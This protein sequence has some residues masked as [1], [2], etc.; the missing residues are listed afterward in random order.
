MRA[1]GL[2]RPFVLT[3]AGALA[4]CTSHDHPQVS[5]MNWPAVDAEFLAASSATLGFKLGTPRFV[6]FAPD[7]TLLF[8]RTPARSRTAELFQ[9]DPT[10]AVSTVAT[11]EQLL[12]GADEHLSDADKARRERTR[13]VTQGIVDVELSRDGARLLV[14]LGERMFLV[15]RASGAAR[16][17]DLSG[18]A[19]A[20]G[21][22][23]YP[24]DPHFSPDGSRIAY[25]VDGDLFVVDT[26]GG[27][28]R[29]LTTRE[30][31]TIEHGVAEFVAQEELFRT[32][33]YWWSPDG[34]H[35]VYQRTDNGP[36]D[37]L[38]VAD[39]VHPEQAPV[40]FRYPRAG[41]P[42][43]EI[44]LGIVP[45]AGGATTWV[46]WDHA[47]YPYLA[48]VAWPDR[49]PL[50]LTVL[51]RDQNE[52]VVLAVHP[53]TG[54]TTP[55]LTE[56]DDAW[57]EAVK[58]VPR[59]LDDGSGFL[60]MS[61]RS[62]E[63]QL[64]LR[65]RGGE[66][67]RALTPPGFGLRRMAGVDLARGVAWVVASADP[68]RA[69]VWLVPLDGKNP[70]RQVSTA[71]G[72]WSVETAEHGDLALA[73]GALADG[74]TSIVVWG[75]DGSTRSTVPSAAEKPPYQAHPTFETVELAGRRYFTATTRPRAFDAT[76]RYPVLVHVYGGPGARMVMASP[77]DFAMDQWY[78]DAGFIVVRIDGRGTPNQGR[79][80]SRAV[81][82]DLVT[83]PL[84][85]Q[86]DALAALGARHGELDLG[87]V[88]IYGWS[89]GGYLAAMAV[90]LRP[91]IF[92]CAVAGAPVTDWKL[93]DTA[94]T[95]RYMKQP[96]ENPDGY[97]ATSALTHAAKLAR[98]LLVIHGLTDDNV[99]VAHSLAL[100][101]A[102]FAAGKRADFVP[103]SST[104][105][106]PDPK[107]LLARET[108]QIDFFREH[109]GR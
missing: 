52:L 46:T 81:L 12:S 78:A 16:A 17:I 36:V 43:A 79:A 53:T 84:A 48:Q 102:L 75:S 26:S 65:D 56:H 87:R 21:A 76:H 30:R 41:R 107:I 42:N 97:A 10:G 4:A 39:A 2:A 13:T 58:G 99:H 28:P 32:R 108:L 45:S 77:H 109:L 40:P 33:G 55:L 38:Y 91:E 11:A 67:V 25:V 19:F 6:A 92:R 73:T 22:G 69:D 85:D 106:V 60:W 62:G 54:A 80:W 29:R 34:G 72:V 66:H 15:E 61:E 70:P 8:L 14:P 89:F 35:I 37:V 49:G 96:S 93:Y 9:L 18:P 23:A 83:V 74:S 105:M 98:P 86:V 100:V 64:E 5:A 44:G 104:H 95:E 1:N 7:G 51:D 50:T 31:E 94:Y 88:G 3:L 63:W 101:Q 82:R 20:R 71:P 68:T 47:K 59:W 103:L 57:V 90:L 24:Y 27:K